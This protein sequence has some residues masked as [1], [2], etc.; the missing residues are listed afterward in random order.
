VAAEVEW[1]GKVVF[2]G[3]IVRSGLL[4]AI[5]NSLIERAVSGYIDFQQDCV[6]AASVPLA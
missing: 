2:V 1:V 4:G 3:G 6:S 5:R